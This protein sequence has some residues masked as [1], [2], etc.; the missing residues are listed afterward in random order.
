M[1]VKTKALEKHSEWKGKL[2]TVLKEPITTREELAIAYTP[3]VAEPCLEIERDESL[4]YEYT[5][6]GNF[7]AV[8]TDGTA[9]LG[10]GDI[11]PSASMPVMEGKC[12]LFKT[13]AGI[14]A[15]P[16]CIDSK[17]TQTIIDTILNISK[18][19]G[20][21]NLE[22]ISAP[23]CF[24]I[25]RALIEK[26]DVPVFHDDQHG[27]AIITSAGMINAI[28][29]TGRE[30]GN[31]KIVINGAGSAGIS[32]AKLF[33]QIGFGDVILCDRDG[34]I[35]DGAPNINPEQQRMALVTNKMKKKGGLAD[36]IKG[37]DAFVGVSKPNLLTE[38]MVASMADKPI[39]FA[40]SNPVPEILPELA[41]RAGAAVVGTGRSDY[42]NQTNNVL[43]FPGIF[44]GVLAVRASRITDSMKEAAAYAIAEAIDES[45]LTEDYIL[46]DVFDH[47]VVDNVAEAVA[48]EA[49]KLGINGV[50]G[51]YEV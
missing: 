18:S 25:E 34:A 9:V 16:L 42:P 51:P 41:K 27:T 23:R 21:I 12:A 1:D 48:R 31:L 35:Y 36:I 24:E 10:L 3:G 22:D 17:D 49:I 2:E 19:F 45:E 20:G 13:F 40:M 38:E 26:C 30:L 43:A 5:G 47:R 8:I 46:P 29:F 32:I 6:K 37:A 28:K 33:L 15:V 39:I 7:V 11:G 4:A 50:G 14:N 44:K